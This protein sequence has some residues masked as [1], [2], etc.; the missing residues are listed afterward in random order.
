MELRYGVNP[1]Q[2]ATASLGEAGSPMTLLAGEPSYINVLDA[3]NSWQ[4]VREAKLSLSL[5]VATPF[6]HVSPA[7]A[8]VCGEIDD[9]M[10]RTWDIDVAALTRWLPPT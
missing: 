2:R 6:K 1:E 5:P 9:V 4:L 10:R 3:V 8:A 7:G